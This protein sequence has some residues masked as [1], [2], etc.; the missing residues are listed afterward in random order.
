M[1]GAGRCTFFAAS[2]GFGVEG[3]LAFTVGL[4]DFAGE[5]ALVGQDEFLAETRHMMV[6]FSAHDVDKSFVLTAM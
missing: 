1:E 4:R 5:F 2:E 6:Q 3:F